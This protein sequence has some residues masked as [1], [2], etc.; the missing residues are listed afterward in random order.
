M[1]QPPYSSQPTY[2]PPQGYAPPPQ[3]YGPYV[4][5]PVA[6][7]PVRGAGLGVVAF[8]LAAVAA[9]GTSIVGAVAAFRIGVGTGQEITLTTSADDFDWS[10]L[11]PV[12]DWVLLGEVAFWVGT[13][14]G[15]WALV[16]GIIAITKNAGRGWGIAAVV[17]ATIGPIAFGTGVQLCLIA[18]FASGFAPS[19]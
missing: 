19:S 13:A 1:T 8:V 18:G 11:T 9:V 7:P 17:V 16:Q 3:G 15:I 12:R 10:L 5:L 6:A 4:P 2:A 14:L